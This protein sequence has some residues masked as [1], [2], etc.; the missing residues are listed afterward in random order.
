MPII[1]SLPNNYAKN[2]KAYLRPIPNGM[3]TSFFL[4]TREGI[5]T[6]LSGNLRLSILDVYG[7]NVIPNAAPIQTTTASGGG[8]RIYVEDMILTGLNFNSIY[9]PVIY[10]ITT[11]L[12]L[13]R[14]N[15][16]R[17]VEATP[18]YV[19]ISYRHSSDRDNYDY[20]QIPTYRNVI[21]LDLNVIDDQGEYDLNQYSEA[22]TG[23]VRNQKSQLK[24]FV[25]LESFFFDAISHGGM[26][27]LS[28]HDDILL[29][30]LPF[31]VKEGYTKEPDIRSGKSKGVIEMW[32][33]G[34]NEINLNV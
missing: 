32:D 9:R 11:N 21:Y 3:P 15:C 20:S 24:S 1:N 29:N 5:T 12:R 25:S 34:L 2:N 26:K 16:F 18:Q 19:E 13:G 8:Y 4:N 22:S 14:L 7:V 17:F 30:G 33:Q 31:Q 6:P 28:L 10:D 23:F 27:G